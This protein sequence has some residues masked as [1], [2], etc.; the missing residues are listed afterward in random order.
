MVAEN[1]KKYTRL[2]LFLGI[3]V[4]YVLYPNARPDFTK[5]NAHDSESYIALSYNFLHGLGYT[6]NMDSH[7]YIPHTLW[8]PGMPLLLTP[9][10]IISGDTVNWLAVKYTM[11][12]IALLGIFLTWQYVFRLTRNKMLAD[13]ITLFIGLNPFYW[14]FSRIAM[15]EVPS[16]VWIIGSLLLLDVVWKNPKVKV[17]TVFLTGAL[18][19]LG[20]MIKGIVI[21]L[22]TVPVVYLLFFSDKLTIKR[23]MLL[24]SVYVVGFSLAFVMW[25]VRNHSV[26]K[27]NLGFD[28]VNQIQMLFKEIPEDPHSPYRNTK[29]LLQTAEENVIWHG[30]YH[31]SSQIVPYLWKANLK[32][33]EGG[34]LIAVFI[35][36]VLLLSVLPRS[37]LVL[38]LYCTILPIVLMMLL[39]TIGGSER[40][41]GPISLL[42]FVGIALQFDSLIKNTLSKSTKTKYILASGI[43]V[44]ASLQAISLVSYIYAHELQPYTTIEN[45]DDLAILFE[46]NRNYCLDK[47]R[48]EISAV[49]TKNEHAFQLITACHAPMILLARNINPLFS[50]AVIDKGRLKKVL[51]PEQIISEEGQWM[52]IRL[53]SLMH[54]KEIQKE[55]Y[56][57]D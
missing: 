3:V 21:G 24:V 25:S 18:I 19:G 48:P 55:Y 45:R 46:K 38:P 56:Q 6:R 22:V 54:S 29:Q 33:Q 52:F 39:I 4:L 14:H 26:D 41:W 10:V 36:L 8:P 23:N 5:F 1:W 53:D 40:Y 50:H 11:I 44:L 9:A 42:C 47:N 35:C 51:G 57:Q 15:A 27:E 20:M 43:A 7:N 30:I 28:G 32:I 13:I 34:S 49:Y 16:Y 2:C 17:H 37:T 12:V 31:F